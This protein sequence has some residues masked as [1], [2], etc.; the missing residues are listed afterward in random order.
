MNDDTHRVLYCI[1][2]LDQIDG[3]WVVDGEDD[4]HFVRSE[5]EKALIEART[6]EPGLQFRL[7]EYV[8]RFNIVIKEEER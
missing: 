5:A 2:C 6:E 7:V 3:L 1:E 8:P 4:V